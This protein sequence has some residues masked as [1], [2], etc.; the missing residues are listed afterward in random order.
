MKLKADREGLARIAQL[1][2]DERAYFGLTREEVAQK[3]GVCVYTLWRLEAHETVYPRFS[4]VVNILNALGFD[5]TC[6][7]TKH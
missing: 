4:T 2:R 7:S 6:H 3:A 1:I 5:V